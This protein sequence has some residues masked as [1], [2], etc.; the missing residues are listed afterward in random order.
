DESRRLR[1]PARDSHR[2]GG[3][4][5]ENPRLRAGLGRPQDRIADEREGLVVERTGDVDDV[6]ARRVVLGQHGERQTS[7][8]EQDGRKEEPFHGEGNLRSAYRPLRPGGV[9]RWLWLRLWQ[10][11]SS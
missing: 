2:A 9:R 10:G 1:L 7:Q 11:S 4:K 5:L 6:E 8:E 3:V